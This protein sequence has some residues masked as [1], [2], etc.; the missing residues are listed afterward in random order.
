MNLN[1]FI[2]YMGVKKQSD[3]A[4]L[5][6]KKISL[7]KIFSYANYL[8]EK[9]LWD[10]LSNI[11]SCVSDKE[12]LFFSLKKAIKASK[13]G[14]MLDVA[15]FVKHL[16]EMNMSDVQIA[17]FVL[18]LAQTMFNRNQNIERNEIQK[19]D[20]VKNHDAEI[21]EAL[22][23]LDMIDEIA[24]SMKHYN[25]VG[26]QG[27]S[28]IGVI[29][30]MQ[31]IDLCKKAKSMTY[32]EVYVFT[33][34][35]YLWA[36]IDGLSEKIKNHLS[37]GKYLFEVPNISEEIDD[38]NL[39]TEEGRQYI[40]GLARKLN[41]AF[42][43]EQPFVTYK[44]GDNIPKGYFQGRTYLQI[45]STNGYQLSETDMVSDLYQTLMP[46]EKVFVID[47]KLQ[48]YKRPDT[49]SSAETTGNFI[50]EKIMSGQYSGSEIS[51]LI[52]SNNPYTIRQTK[53]VERV[54]NKILQSKPG[55]NIKFEIDGAGFA[56]KQSNDI[57]ISELAALVSEVW[58]SYFESELKD[59]S[60][61]ETDLPKLLYQTRQQ[62][63]QDPG[64]LPTEIMGAD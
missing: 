13:N 39:T 52:V 22:R 12:K 16:E 10:A 11:P 26:L 46:E 8:T 3:E 36:E 30:R 19:S 54:F 28:R 61:I 17:D 44:N 38:K 31:Y 27:A 56:S 14:D 48:G 7:F 4:I 59:P 35:R 53:A 37:D 32:G 47:S 33:G 15:K 50:L 41:V 24:P 6:E 20:W 63:H 25:I 1:N 2:S 40:A 43:Q 21:H 60:H 62:Y 5:N 55:L 64:E 18:Y 51:I 23:S 34:Q 9:E 58:R 42:N 49:A 29:A 45:D 57:A